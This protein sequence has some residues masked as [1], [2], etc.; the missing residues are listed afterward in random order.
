MA[1]FLGTPGLGTFELPEILEGS[2]GVDD[3]ASYVNAGGANGGVFVDLSSGMAFDV[4]NG[5][6]DKLISIEN[7]TGSAFDDTL[8]GDDGANVL[9]GGA[10]V[11][12]MFGFGGNDT[13]FGGAGD[14]T[15]LDGGAGDDMLFGGDGI[16]NL[17]G[18]DGDDVLSGDAGDDVLSGGAGADVFK[19]SFDL[20]QGEGGGEPISFTEFFADHGG[21]VTEDGK[22]AEGTNQGQFSSLYTQWLESLGLTV[23]D[24][25]QNNSDSSGTP[26]VDGPDGTFGERESFT[27][28]SGGGKKTV[29]HERWYS[30]TWTADTGSGGGQDTVASDDGFDTI[31]DFTWGVDQLE[32]NGLAGLTLDQFTSLFDVSGVDADLD[33]SIDDTVLALADGT[34]G[35]TLLNESGHTEAEF[36]ATSIFS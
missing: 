25:G 27:W 22:V 6:W 7:V 1:T 33:G 28:T 19:Y 3:T 36:H 13:L 18:G 17:D 2:D 29:T 5:D 8:A 35:V 24:L 12:L 4:T 14:D 10:G 11:D 23:V 34:W 26:V 20:T 16:D 15:T 31:V 30:D 32:F 9:D 21:A